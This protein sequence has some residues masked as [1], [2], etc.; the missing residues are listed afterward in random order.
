MILK[1]ATLAMSSALAQN[2]HNRSWRITE[3]HQ[4][5]CIM[6]LDVVKL[7]IPMNILFVEYM[8]C[9]NGGRLDSSDIVVP[10]CSHPK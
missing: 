1:L 4:P 7:V 8:E 10:L 2:L 6:E 9:N 3:P 5:P